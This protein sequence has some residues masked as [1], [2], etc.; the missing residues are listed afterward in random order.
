M[1]WGGYSRAQLEAALG[2]LSWPAE[3]QSSSTALDPAE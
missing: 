1:I 2:T 3:P